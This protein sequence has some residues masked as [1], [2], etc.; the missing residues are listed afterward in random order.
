VPGWPSSVY[1]KI[2]CFVFDLIYVRGSQTGVHVPL[3]VH[4]P[5]W[6][7]T[8]NVSNR[9]ENM[10]VHFKLFIHMHLYEPFHAT[11]GVKPEEYWVQ[12]RIKGGGNGGKYPGIPAARGPPWWN[13][14]VAN[15]LHVWKIFV[16]QKRY[17]NT[18]VYYIALSIRGLQQQLISL[19][20]WLSVSFSNRYWIPY[21]YFWFCSMQI[22]WFR[23]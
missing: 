22:Y 12:G 11:N 15:K 10:F 3:V 2:L 20:V 19:Q 18:T 13:L 8:F 6:R 5:V 1:Q 21:E 16:I 4:L 14:F 17:N 7:G 9:R 23:S